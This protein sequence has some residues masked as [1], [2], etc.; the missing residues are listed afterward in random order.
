M[1]R[2]RCRSLRSASCPLTSS[3]ARASA[4][5]PAMDTHASGSIV[6]S[7]MAILPYTLRSSFAS[8]KSVC[9]APRPKE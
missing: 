1:L 9:A 7:L 8:R 6:F 4:A 2:M 5:T 3:N